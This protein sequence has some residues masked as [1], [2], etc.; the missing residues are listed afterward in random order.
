MAGKTNCEMCMNFVYDE[1][2]EDYMCSINMD[3]D[4]YA[5][6]AMG[7]RQEC[8]YFRFGDEYTIVRKQN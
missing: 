6:L 8:P 4:E 1:E 7:Y 5:R 3:E 2:Y